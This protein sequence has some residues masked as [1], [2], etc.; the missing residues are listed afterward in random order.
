MR[1]IRT[2]GSVRDGVG[3]VPIYSASSTCVSSSSQ[4]ILFF[5]YHQG[6]AENAAFCASANQDG[7]SR[8]TSAFSTAN[9]A[10]PTSSSLTSICFRSTHALKE[11]L[12]PEWAKVVSDAV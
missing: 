6:G 5:L 3:N 7:D 2:S 11:M 10:I 4:K 9:A 1:E 8:I 12:R